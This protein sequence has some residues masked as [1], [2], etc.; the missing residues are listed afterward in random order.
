VQAQIASQQAIAQG[1]AQ[2]K[3]AADQALLQEKQKQEQQVLMFKAQEDEKERQYKMQEAEQHRQFLQSQEQAKQ[4][5]EDRATTM[6]TA[7][8]NQALK[9]QE[10]LEQFKADQDARMTAVNNEAAMR[11]DQ[12]KADNDAQLAVLQA[13]LTSQ[14]AT[15]APEPLDVTGM[16]QPI[17][18]GMQANTQAMMEQLAKGLSGLHEAHTAPR[19]A[20][21]IKDAAGNN[22]GVESVITKPGAP[23]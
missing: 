23:A 13:A 9:V 3:Q 21:Y 1:T 22:V 10:Q 15:L 20:R 19:V 2:A 5:A 12:Q 16:I 18:D 6:A 17:I 11:R 14:V 8:E 7:I 4:D